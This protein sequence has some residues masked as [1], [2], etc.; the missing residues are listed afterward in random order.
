VK[1]G[2]FPFQK[3]KGFHCQEN[4]EPLCHSCHNKKTAS[5]AT[6]DWTEPL[7]ALMLQLE[8]YRSKD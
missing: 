5:E 6:T 7:A 8:R 2:L 4:L 3:I 1:A